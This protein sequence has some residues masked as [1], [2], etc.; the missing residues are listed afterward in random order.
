MLR[1]SKHEIP[2]KRRKPTKSCSFCRRKKVKCDQKLPCSTCLRYGNT[3]CDLKVPTSKV[4]KSSV[5]NLFPKLENGDTSNADNRDKLAHPDSENCLDLNVGDSVLKNNVYFE[6]DKEYVIIDDCKQVAGADP[7]DRQTFGPFS[8]VTLSFGDA[9]YMFIYKPVLDLYKKS[10]KDT[11]T[12]LHDTDVYVRECE[13]FKSDHYLPRKAYCKKLMKSNT[14]E[15]YVTFPEDNVINSNY[16]R[17][18]VVKEDDSTKLLNFLKNKIPTREVTEFLLDVFF[19]SLCGF[20]P[21]LDE[22]DFRE[23]IGQILGEEDSV[24]GRFTNINIRKKTDFALV[25]LLLSILR[26]ASLSCSPLPN[27]FNEQQKTSHG[28]NGKKDYIELTSECFNAAKVCM[29]QID[30]YQCSNISAI[31]LLIFVYIIHLYSPEEGGG[32]DGRLVRMLLS[33]IIQLAYS[34]GLHYDPSHIPLRFRHSNLDNVA[35][36]IWHFIVY[37]DTCNSIVSGD[38]LFTAVFSSDTE[39][40]MLSELNKNCLNFSLEEETISNLR[41]GHTLVSRLNDILSILLSSKEGANLKDLSR[42]IYHLEL[43]NEDYNATIKKFIS[44]TDDIARTTAVDIVDYFRLKSFLFS[45]YFKLV[46]KYDRSGNQSLSDHYMMKAINHSLRDPFKLYFYF[47]NNSSLY[48]NGSKFFIIPNLILMVQK[49][50]TCV[51]LLLIRLNF[52][53]VKIKMHGLQKDS[54]SERS[55]IMKCEH[56]ISLLLLCFSTSYDIVYSL[57]SSYYLAWR[58]V[59][60]YTLVIS[61][62]QSDEFQ[63]NVARNVL[64]FNISFSE[65]MID[66]IVSTLTETKDENADNENLGL[67]DQSLVN[68]DYSTE[69]SSQFDLEKNNND[70]WPNAAQYESLFENEYLNNSPMMDF[71]FNC[72]IDLDLDF[73][74][75]MANY[76]S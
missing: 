10:S 7:R 22:K 67:D 16:F 41:K 24:N 55:I 30:L 65:K 70:L 29:D 66:T 20:I 61:V 45:L 27:I 26:I 52:F 57:R 23:K 2:K 39:L 76:E 5:T 51:S 15:K 3:D 42:R 48:E 25:G 1:I 18:I 37:M 56:A 73:D 64:H 13:R 62:I 63:E 19:G 68:R 28:I 43:L 14:A 54:T 60:V 9:Y 71:F 12:V 72:G 50:L 36:K 32:I 58:L 44:G 4:G 21:V 74:F 47:R 17:D 35:R 53:K 31:Q 38:P 49:S 69:L 46:L 59:R 6:S 33:N 40:P 8:W 11:G 75:G 34:I